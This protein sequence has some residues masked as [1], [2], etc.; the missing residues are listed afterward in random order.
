[1]LRFRLV[2]TAVSFCVLSTAFFL[3]GPIAP[4]YAVGP[5]S[6]IATQD[7]FSGNYFTTTDDGPTSI[8]ISQKG[9]DIT[10]TLSMAGAT[11]NLKGTADGGRI[12]GTATSSEGSVSFVLERVNDTLHLTL[13]SEQEMSFPAPIKIGKPAPADSP[14]EKAQKRYSAPE[15]KKATAP[16]AR[17]LASIEKSVPKPRSVS[18]PTTWKTF[19]SPIGVTFRYPNTWKMTDVNGLLLLVPP[20]ASTNPNN[21]SEIYS[22]VSLP[23]P[24]VESA[25][26][27]RLLTMADGMVGRMFPYMQRSSEGERISVAGKDGIIVT[28]D[29]NNPTTGKPARIRSH[30][31]VHEGVLMQLQAWGDRQKVSVHEKVLRDIYLS[32]RTGPTQHDQRIVG[33]WSGGSTSS[34]RV[35]N[36]ADGRIESSIALQASSSYRLMPDGT[37]LALSVSRSAISITSSSAIPESQRVD[38]NIDTGDQ[39]QW[40]KGRWYAGTGKIAVVMDDGAGFAADYTLTGNVLT[41]RFAGGAAMQLT[42]F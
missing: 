30:A 12:S 37:L 18:V 7:S 25:T 26:D 3:S 32:L 34:D 38:A 22:V 24:G 17:K 39:Q 1:M 6:L 13:G 29:G 36:G 9:N 40:R 14:T 10:G 15:N 28:Y 42:R 5:I 8:K 4:L 23:A 27:P 21:L 41:V 2:R 16:T 20:G 35:R 11:I 31:I 33:N 19:T